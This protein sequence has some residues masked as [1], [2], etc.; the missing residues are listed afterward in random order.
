MDED[1]K[2]IAKLLEEDENMLQAQNM[3]NDFH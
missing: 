3:Q 2:M 1:Q